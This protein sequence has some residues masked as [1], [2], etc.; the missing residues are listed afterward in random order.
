M[1][2]IYIKNNMFMVVIY[3][4]NISIIFKTLIFSFRGQYR[5]DGAAVLNP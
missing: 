5:T 2:T 3:T 1:V 4:E